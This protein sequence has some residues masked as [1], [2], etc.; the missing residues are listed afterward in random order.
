M[1]Y[2]E[3][4][5]ELQMHRNTIIFIVILLLLAV[6]IAAVNIGSMVF[7]PPPSDIIPTLSPTPFITETPEPTPTPMEIKESTRSATLSGTKKTTPTPTLQTQKKI[8]T[9]S[10]G[11]SF[12]LPTYYRSEATDQGAALLNTNTPSEIIMVTCQKDIPK[13]AVSPEKIETRII[14]GGI[15][16]TL[17]HDQSAKDGTPIDV[18]LFR[19]PK[20]GNDIFIAD[21]GTTIETI[22]SSITVVQ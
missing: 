18:I 21:S 20:T 17:Y 5:L 12:T 19:H 3:L 4:L 13:P 8:I 15:P 10:C 14:N 9:T 11:I 6:L 2:N 16:A 1:Y 22:L 7:P